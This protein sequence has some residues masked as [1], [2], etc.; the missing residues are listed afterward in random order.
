MDEF[1]I[2]YGGLLGGL[3]IVI[4][5]CFRILAVHKCVTEMSVDE[6]RTFT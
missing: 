1:L 2:V 3:V 6:D 5:I 4:C